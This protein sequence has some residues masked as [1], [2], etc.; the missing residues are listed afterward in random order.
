MEPKLVPAAA[1]IMGWIETVVDRGI[2]RPGYPA[3]EWTEEW[4]AERFREF[5]LEDVRLEPVSLQRWE[6]TECR[7]E[8]WAT[9]APDDVITVDGFPLP[10][11]ASDTVEAP[12]RRASDETDTDVRGAVILDEVTLS[13]LPQSIARAMAV[14]THDPENEFETLEQVLPFG[15]QFMAM[16]DP[17]M[18]GGAAGYIGALTGFPWETRDYY[19]P[20]DATFRPLPAAWVSGNDGRRLLALLEGAGDGEVRC[21]LTTRSDRE[22][23]T[24]HNVIGT[25]PGASD[26]WVIVASHH[27]APWAS[28]VEDGSGIALVLA[29]AAYWSQI[30]E[31][32]RPHNMCFLLTSG[33]MAHAAGTRAFIDTHRDLLDDTVLE[34]HLEH[35]ARR[36][37]GDENGNL[38]PTDDPEVRWWFVTEQD[39]LQRSV[40]DALQAEDLR[41]SLLFKPDVFFPE[42]PTD[43]AFF[44]SA[45]VPLVHYLT[46]PMYLFDSQDTIDKIHVDSLEPVTRAVIRIIDSL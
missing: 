37:V 24:T 33:H 32:E 23:V 15:A 40:H 30:P 14:A 4:T 10:L 45:G 21:R 13:V 44:H 29:Q 2:R 6:D 1:E 36:C 8:A 18:E 41:R 12:L 38:V 46:A 9:A 31:E 7:V 28:A 26:K 16:L 42:P 11:T 22:E 43:G 27:D 17:A 19:V 39:A 5:G 3:D 35:A 25:L 20:Y 34:I